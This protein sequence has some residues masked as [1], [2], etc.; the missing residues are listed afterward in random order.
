MRDCYYEI[1][2]EKV[3]EAKVRELAQ[4]K[5]EEKYRRYKRQK[6]AK[7]GKKSRN[8]TLIEDEDEDEEKNSPVSGLDE[9]GEGPSE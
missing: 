5:F 4:L 1:M 8:F 9:D 6:N 2:R 7:K 3:L